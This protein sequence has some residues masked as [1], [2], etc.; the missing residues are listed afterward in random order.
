[1]SQMKE[2]NGLIEIKV[3]TLV[4]RAEENGKRI[5][6]SLRVHRVKLDA[7]KNSY[8]KSRFIVQAFNE[9]LNLF[10]PATTF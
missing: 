8:E 4:C 6:G 3:F 2:L 7:T 1:M 10:T 5:H 9:K